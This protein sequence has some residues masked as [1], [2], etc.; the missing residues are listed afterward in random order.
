M[1][2]AVVTGWRWLKVNVSREIVG[3][4]N[5]CFFRSIIFILLLSYLSQNI[6]INIFT[7]KI[8]AEFFFTPIEGSVEDDCSH[9]SQDI[10]LL[11]DSQI[12]DPF[13]HLKPLDIQQW[14][15]IPFVFLFAPSFVHSQNRG[16]PGQRH[17]YSFVKFRLSYL[18]NCHSSFPWRRGKSSRRSYFAMSLFPP[19]T[20]S[21]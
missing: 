6:Y 7:K 20:E 19:C 18:E 5:V 17:S 13:F 4:F 16:I 3:G 15:F 2:R 9:K 12:L 10:K 8:S 11:E 21:L 14:R 1:E